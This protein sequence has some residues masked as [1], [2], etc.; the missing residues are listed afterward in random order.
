M[1]QL[2]LEPQRNHLFKK[3]NTEQRR[4]CWQKENTP[5]LVIKQ[6]STLVWLFRYGEGFEMLEKS[7]R[8]GVFIKANSH[9][10]DRH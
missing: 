5:E 6:E 3:K 1:E 8:D 2:N 4:V 7:C 10:T 9:H